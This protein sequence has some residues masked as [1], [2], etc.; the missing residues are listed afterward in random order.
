MKLFSLFCLL[1]FALVTQSAFAGRYY[2]SATGRWLTI[3]PKADKFRGWSSY[4]YCKNNPLNRIDP[5]GLTDIKINIQRTTETSTSTVG[6]FNVTNS[7]N[8]K[9]MHGYTLELP[10]RNNQTAISRVNA[11][12]YSGELSTSTG[13]GE[14]I[15]LEDKNDR[16]GIL[17]HAGNTSEDTKGCILV[18]N[19]TSTDFVG[20]SQETKK[21]LVNY[22]KTIVNSDKE[23]GESTTIQVIVSDPKKNSNFPYIYFDPNSPEKKKD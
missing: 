14:V 18:G 20:G 21:A 10:D 7:S 6:F 16:A 2:D 3:D 4:T 5:D 17:I 19:S 1:F 8:E 13:K 23:N 22:V 11:D 15:R 12:T 9:S